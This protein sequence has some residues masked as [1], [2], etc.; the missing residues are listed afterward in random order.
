MR[1]LQLCKKFP[2]PLKDGESIAVTSLSKA[3]HNAGAEICLL[4]MNTSKH[5]FDMNQTP[6]ELAH[7]QSIHTVPVDNR[8]KPM[9]A[10]L[11]L[12]SG[13]SY[14]VSRFISPDFEKTLVALLHTQDFDVIQ[15]ESLY[16][17]PYI[18]AIRANSKAKVV[19]RAHNVEHEI[20]E[21]VV[22]NTRF[23]PKKLYLQ[24]LVNKLKR[25]EINQLREYDLLAAISNRDL[26]RFTQMGYANQ[27]VV[28]PIGISLQAYQP[29]FDSYH[30]DLSIGFIGSLDWTPNVEGVHWFLM[31]VWGEISKKFSRLK[32]HIA[33][34]NPPRWI[35]DIKMNN[36]KVLGEVPDAAQFMN[37]HSILVVPLLSGSGMRAKILE[38]M[39][40]G[41]IVITTS[42]GL[43]GIPASDKQE[44]LI[45]NNTAEF[46]D[47]LQ[48]CHQQNGQL[49]SMGKKAI[50]FVSNHF[51]YQ[52]IGR[53]L[54]ATYRN[55]LPSPVKV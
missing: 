15:L 3:L 27:A 49:E 28:T 12:F 54:M 32:L 44:V 20:W 1:I 16:L 52:Q 53:Q 6:E 45:A 30:R 55:L 38:A 8:I 26:S 9:D 35:Q 42:I 39:A 51:E 50:E 31:E 7:Y 21:R 17:A 18:P 40:L 37:Q 25:F 24:H 2:Y 33:G 10:F 43:E 48:Y 5:F 34:R 41:K 13:S 11:N 22:K 23:L 4:A 47:A 19:M 14:H 29:D 46:I 36:I